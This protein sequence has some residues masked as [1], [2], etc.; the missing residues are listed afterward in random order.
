MAAARPSAELDFAS[1]QRGNAEM[2]RRAQEVIDACWALGDA[3]PIAP[4]H[5]IGAGGL[6]NAVPEIVDH[7]GCGARHRFARDSE[8]RA[9]HVPMELWCN[10]AQERYVLAI[11]ARDVE[12]FARSCDRERC[13][14]AV[15]G[16]LTAKRDLVVRD[17]T[18][19][20]A[21][22]E[23][24]MDVLFGKPPKMTRRARVRV[25]AAPAW[26]REHVAR[27]GD[28]SRAAFPAVADKSFLITIGDRTVGGLSSARPA[29]RPVASAGQRC[30][31]DC[32]SFEGYRGEAI[33][34]GERTPVAIHDGP[35]SARLA[36]AEAITNIAAA[37][38]V[39]LARHPPIGELDGGGRRPGNDDYALYAMVRAVGEELCPALGIAIPVGKDSLSMRTV[40]QDAGGKPQA[41]T[42][43]VSL[44]VSAFAPVADVRR[45]LTPELQSEPAARRSC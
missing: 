14:F 34:M 45:T 5:D 19:G 36:V 35:A 10:E 4:I 1:V 37:D 25:V 7:S 44:I 27:R 22:V 24:P 3:N 33:A 13:P 15:I 17:A 16:E 30:R 29:G 32:P 12:R 43:P 2:Q 21:P 28:R 8:R 38:V 26:Q 9:R 41:V 23:M 31:S 39:E 11:E 40:W 6:S 18:L 42:A 20:N